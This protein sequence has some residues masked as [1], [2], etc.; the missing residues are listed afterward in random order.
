MLDNSSRR[1]RDVTSGVLKVNWLAHKDWLH[2]KSFDK[3]RKERAELRAVRIVKKNDAPAAYE[4]Q[5]VEQVAARAV[6]RVVAVNVH[7]IIGAP[8]KCGEHIV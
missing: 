1:R 5:A 3:L 6:D 8:C 2:G 4:I 7:E